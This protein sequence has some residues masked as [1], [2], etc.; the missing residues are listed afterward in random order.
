MKISHLPGG[1]LGGV[2]PW[3]IA[4]EP[5]LSDWET[6]CVTGI[7]RG[8]LTG[9][10][11]IGAWTIPNGAE[12]IPV[13]TVEIGPTPRGA[14]PTVEAGTPPGVTWAT[15]RG[16]VIGGTALR[17]GV[18]MGMIGGAILGGVT[19]TPSA[20]PGTKGGRGIGGIAGGVLWSMFVVTLPEIKDNKNTTFETNGT[21]NKQLIH[22]I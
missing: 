19:P 18:L 11:A 13:E 16:T 10:I 4:S 3:P 22:I 12:E 8:A 17:C 6:G 20:A 5:L 2:V 14:I 1:G 7:P 15:L 21:N 9:G